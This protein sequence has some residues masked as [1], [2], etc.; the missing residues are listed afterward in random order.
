MVKALDESTGGGHELS[1]SAEAEAWLAY[2]EELVR[3]HRCL[4]AY[5]V[6]RFYTPTPFGCG[7]EWGFE[8]SPRYVPV[9]RPHRGQRRA[10]GTLA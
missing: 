2:S 6:L 5:R 3:L 10:R 7:T 4:R 9:S 8:L 1:V